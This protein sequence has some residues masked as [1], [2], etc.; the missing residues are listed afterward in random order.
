MAFTLLLC[1]MNLSSYSGIW[2]LQVDLYSWCCVLFRDLT[3]AWIIKACCSNICFSF[4]M[5][6]WQFSKSK[7]KQNIMISYPEPTKPVQNYFKSC[8]WQ[9]I[10]DS[11]GD[12]L[13][14]IIASWILDYSLVVFSSR[15][16]T[17]QVINVQILFL[18]WV[19]ELYN[20]WLN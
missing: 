2:G 9:K 8:C 16:K 18:S 11:F 12:A 20:L 3:A 10:N 15:N 5:L 17:I 7:W 14:I 19:G 4:F 6:T 1:F 13:C